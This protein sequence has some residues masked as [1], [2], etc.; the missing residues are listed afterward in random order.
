[1]T[2]I[3]EPFAVV[4]TQLQSMHQTE[5]PSDEEMEEMPNPQPQEEPATEAVGQK[6]K[7]QLEKIASLGQSTA[8]LEMKATTLNQALSWHFARMAFQYWR[9]KLQLASLSRKQFNKF[10]SKRSRIAYDAGMLGE[11]MMFKLFE[12]DGITGE[13]V[14]PEVRSAR[15]KCVKDIQGR[16]KT[17]DSLRKKALASTFFKTRMQLYVK[18]EGEP[19]QEEQRDT[20]E[21]SEHSDAVQAQQME[22]ECGEE[23]TSERQEQEDEEQEDEAEEEEEESNEQHGE[24]DQEEWKQGLPRW[25]PRVHQREFAG[26]LKLITDMGGVDSS[27]ISVDVDEEER[28]LTIRAVKPLHRTRTSFYQ[29][30]HPH[31]WCEETFQLPRSLSSKHAQSQIEGR[32][33]VITIPFSSMRPTRN[34][35]ASK[36]AANS[37]S[38]NPFYQQPQQATYTSARRPKG[39][40]SGFF[41]SQRSPFDAIFGF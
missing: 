26:G 14:A 35:S 33:L 13:D 27:T 18:E 41:P 17:A 22:E 10:E 34:R 39:F 1:M 12:L 25:R 36:T 37:R 2:T 30:R 38:Y 11:Q 21:T 8:L 4:D 20:T 15:R 7:E 31:G 32:Y 9:C 6:V 19:E 24:V 28:T 40:S 5:A 16:M 29:Y 23:N 3:Q